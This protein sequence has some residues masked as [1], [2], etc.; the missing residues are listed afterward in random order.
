MLYVF[1]LRLTLGKLYEDPGYVRSINP[2]TP[3]SSIVT[4]TWET[5]NICWT[6]KWLQASI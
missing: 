5:L 3:V 2:C 1:V 4:G 6:S